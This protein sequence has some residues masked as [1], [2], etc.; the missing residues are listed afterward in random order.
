MTGVLSFQVTDRDP[1]GARRGILEVPHGRVETPAFMPV[2]TQGSVKSLSSADLETLGVQVLL[3]NAYHLW[4]R[5]GDERIARLGGL[6]RFM[7]WNGPILT[8]SGGFQVMSL[9]HVRRID[10]EG[11]LFRSHLD[12]TPLRLTPEESVRI[13]TRLGSDIMMALDECPRLPADRRT[14]ER[15]VERTTAWAL[16]SLEARTEGRGAL[17]GIV[18]GG[19][20]DELRQRSL[21][22]LQPLPFE[23]LALGGLSVGEGS[24]PMR[25]AVARW[26]PRMP[27]DRPRYLMGIGRPEDLVEA[28]HAGMDMFDSVFPTRNA[29]NGGVFT[30]TGSL[31]LKRADNADDAGPIDEDC[32]C[33]TCRTYS[34]AYLRHLYLS[35]EI[36][37][38]RLATVHNLHH[39]LE[40]MR[41][42]REAIRRGTFGVWRRDFW[43]RRGLSGPPPL[44][45]DTGTLGR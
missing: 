32:R 36:L 39:V 37:V 26:A 30:A 8:D 34:L 13:Q 10:D 28:V 44:E 17:F 23:G 6:H 11:V 9:A 16:R 25:A 40:L 14:L 20:D 24:E 27:A 4:V 31:L 19:V 45:A 1:S 29:R 5:P 41:G 12:G 2:G 18:Q 15:A 21:E 33:E 35:R 38:N 43:R 42:M 7:A 3:G 22:E